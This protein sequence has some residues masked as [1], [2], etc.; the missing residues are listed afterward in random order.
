[1]APMYRAHGQLFLPLFVIV[2]SNSRYPRSRD[3]SHSLQLHK[4]K[5]KIKLLSGMGASQSKQDNEQVFYNPVPIQV[6]DAFQSQCVH[7]QLTFPH[8]GFYRARQSALRRHTL[9]RRLTRPP[10]GTRRRRARQN[11]R[12]GGAT[13]RRRRCPAPGDRSCA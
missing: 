1:M 6:D 4:Q 5:L 13:T 11:Q 10:S 7:H 8:T 9:P 3:G 2:S 12:R